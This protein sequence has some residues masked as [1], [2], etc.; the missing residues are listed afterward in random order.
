MN[1][2]KYQ[3]GLSMIV[4]DEHHVIERLLESVYKHIDYWV[5]VDTG[6]T[7]G[8]QEIIRKFFKDKDVPGEL[9]ETPWVDFSTCRNIALQAV[10]EK[11]NWGFWIDA[12]EEFIPQPGF[13]MNIVIANASSLDTVSVPTK[14][15]PIDYTRKSIWKCGRNFKWEGPI[16]EILMTADEQPGGLLD[17]G[18]VLVK[19]E[20]SSWQDVKTK[21]S[22][23][24]KILA[25]Y[26]EENKDS[27]WVFYA[28]QS[29]RDAGENEKAFEWYKKR[30]EMRE[31]YT[32]EIFVSKY[33]LA[34]IG[35]VLEKP[36]TEILE[37]YN[38]AHKEDPVR[39]ESIKSLVQY[40][41]RL[42]DWELAYIYSQY[43]LRYNLKNPYPQR[44]LFI[45]KDLYQYQMMELHSLSCYYTK[46]AEEGSR[47][48]WQMRSQ[49]LPNSLSEAQR[50]V[51][52]ENEKYFL[53]ISVLQAA[54]KNAI[55]PGS[56]VPPTKKGSNYMPPKKKK[57]R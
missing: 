15:G 20:G 54:A 23:H 16:H 28:A 45:D 19:S 52:A 41:H 18:Y 29:Y 53:P 33:M 37:L 6:S 40:L 56:A 42:Q 13:N 35:E 57:K 48:Y 26:T 55:A 49:I 2:E 9:I 43:G 25:A 5:I 17:G 21:Y 31:G 27:R 44:I 47:A 12:D 10:E 51:I 22:N 30:A 8:T 34:R 11:C 14:Y 24:A 7:D 36:R 32:E 50:A 3:L 4:K 1:Q 39:G 38:E 46:R